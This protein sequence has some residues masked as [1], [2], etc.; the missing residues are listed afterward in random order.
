MFVAVCRLEIHIESA[1][2]LKD[3]R[4][5]VQSLIHRVGNQFRVS[6]AEIEALEAHNLAVL[7]IATVSN[8]GGHARKMLE[9]AVRFIERTRL[10]AEVGQ[11]EFDVLSAL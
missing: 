7:G 10:D 2:S 4:G 1:S 6:I 5:V 8:D 11:V 9:E 3:K